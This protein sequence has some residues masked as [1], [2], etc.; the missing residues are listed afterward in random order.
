MTKCQSGSQIKYTELLTNEGSANSKA[1]I[2]ADKY[3]SQNSLDTAGAIEFVNEVNGSLP[4][5][6][7]ND[8]RRQV[9][10]ET[11]SK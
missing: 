3:R 6:H 1:A 2:K 10:Y 4:E 8:S 11:L 5:I 7:S 9:V